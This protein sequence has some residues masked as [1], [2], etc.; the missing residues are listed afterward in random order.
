MMSMVGRPIGQLI[1]ESM[2]RFKAQ[3]SII[4]AAWRRVGPRGPTL[5]LEPEE[6]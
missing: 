6:C 3:P 2:V 4:C 1:R 5:E